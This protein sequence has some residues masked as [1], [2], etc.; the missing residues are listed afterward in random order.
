MPELLGLEKFTNNNNDNNEN[1]DKDKVTIPIYGI[2][3]VS[4]VTY[5][6]TFIKKGAIESLANITNTFIFIVFVIVN[7]LVLTYYYKGMDKNN[8]NKN[9]IKILEGFPWYA[10]C[11]LI[12]SLI[13]LGKSFTYT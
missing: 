9:K 3:A 5:L 13:Y 7:I 8:K 11:G 1:N 6:L 4:I 12:L 2:I 10:V